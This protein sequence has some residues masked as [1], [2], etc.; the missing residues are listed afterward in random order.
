MLDRCFIDSGFQF[1]IKELVNPSYI[2][3]ICVDKRNPNLAIRYAFLLPFCL[4]PVDLNFIKLCSFNEFKD[5]HFFTI[6]YWPVLI[7]GMFTFKVLLPA[8]TCSYIV[9]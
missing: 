3:K 9:L 2:V 5:E 1:T 4:F 7:L 8:A 6:F